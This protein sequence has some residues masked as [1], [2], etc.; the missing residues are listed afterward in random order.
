MPKL[1]KQETGVR[2]KNTYSPHPIPLPLPRG[3][4][5][6]LCINIY[7]FIQHSM[8]DVHFP[9][10]TLC[11]SAFGALPLC[12]SVPLRWFIIRI[13]QSEIALLHHSNTP[14]SITQKHV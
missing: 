10:V 12:Y 9:S 11:L 1:R 13:C 6:E 2:S 5:E 4:R 7:L 8:F 14:V 3:A